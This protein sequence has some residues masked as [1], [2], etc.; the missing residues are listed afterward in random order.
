MGVKNDLILVLPGPTQSVRRIFALT[1][2]RTC[3]EASGSSS[4]SRSFGKK[5]AKEIYSYGKRLTIIIDLFKG[6]IGR[7]T[8]SALAPVLGPNPYNIML[9]IKYNAS[10]G[11]VVVVVVMFKWIFENMPVIA[12][13]KNKCQS[14]APPDPLGATT[15][16]RPPH[17]TPLGVPGERMA[18][19]AR[20][21]KLVA[22]R[23][24]LSGT[25]RSLPRVAANRK[26]MEIPARH[27]G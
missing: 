27:R 23:G 21:G 24:V 15:A 25:D 12:Y 18:A 20:S 19:D 26:K 3:L 6:L 13:P 5:T 7:E 8:F 17:T 22:W 16:P 4:G 9:F 1:F 2:V 10:R 14:R 11:I